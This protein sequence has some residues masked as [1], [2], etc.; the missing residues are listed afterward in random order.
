MKVYR[1]SQCMKFMRLVI[2]LRSN[3]Y[4]IMVENDSAKID[5]D[6]NLVRNK[7]VGSI[8]FCK[9]YTILYISNN[10]EV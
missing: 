1:D 5:N 10:S 8:I 3:E 4:K 2:G 7:N 9:S 6:I